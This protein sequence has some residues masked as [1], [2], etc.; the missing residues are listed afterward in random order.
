MSNVEPVPVPATVGH[1]LVGQWIFRSRSWRFVAA[2]LLV[3]F[4]AS[5]LSRPLSGSY[6]PIPSQPNLAPLQVSMQ[7]LSLNKGT[8]T[9]A[10]LH[11]SAAGSIQYLYGFGSVLDLSGSLTGVGGKA[12]QLVV[13]SDQSLFVID[14]RRWS[15][16]KG[17]DPAHAVFGFW[18][19]L[20][21][22]DFARVQ[23][24][25][26]LLDVDGPL[27]PLA[28]SALTRCTGSG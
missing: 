22:R 3:A 12:P 5:S 7:Q 21:T 18:L 2:V 16:P 17:A 28:Y 10:I 4:F 13:R 24:P 8:S 19:R 14:A 6:P 1:R 27:H 9:A 26:V 15:A 23:R 25:C 11:S 20:G